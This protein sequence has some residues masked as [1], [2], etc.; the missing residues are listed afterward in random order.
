M[1][2]R[3]NQRPCPLCGSLMHRQSKRCRVCYVKA[4]LQSPEARLR[5]SQQRQGKPS[6]IRT[7]E[8]RE[9]MSER[10]LGKH[11]NWN[12]ASKRPEVAQKIKD[13]WTPERREIRRQENLLRNV[14]PR[15]RLRYGIPYESGWTRRLK[16]QVLERDG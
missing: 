10:F 14:D 13:W 2:M 11:R 6:Y 7:A 8:H 4:E 1:G 12:S 3:K 9:K 16:S 5:M 15:F